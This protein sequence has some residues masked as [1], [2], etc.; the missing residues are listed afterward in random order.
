MASD[1]NETVQRLHQELK[2]AD[3]I[4]LEVEKLR[5]IKVQFEKSEAALKQTKATFEAQI[6][7]VD[8][9]W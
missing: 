8:A 4:I 6:V 9:D 3:K 5:K 7:A 2:S 1:Q